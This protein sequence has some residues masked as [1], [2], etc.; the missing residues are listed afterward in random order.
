MSKYL[1]IDC[2]PGVDDAATILLAHQSQK[3]QPI[4]IST[5]AGNATHRHT[6][7]NARRLVHLIPANTP[8]YP[9]A[10]KPLIRELTTAPYIHGVDGL[11]GIQLPASEKAVESKKAWDALY[12]ALCRYGDDL[13]ILA[14]G[15]LTNIAIA[16]AKY[17]DFAQR[18]KR[19]IIMGGAAKGG[20]YTPAA[21][22]NIYV[23][24]EAAEKVFMSGIPIFMFG[25]DVT[26][27]SYLTEEDLDALENQSSPQAKFMVDCLQLSKEFAKTKN[28][29]GVPLHDVCTLLYL[30]KPKLFSFKKAWVRVETG[31]EITRGKTVTDL[32]S[33][34]QM[35]PKNTQV[36]LVVRREDFAQLF[37]EMMN[38]YSKG[39]LCK[40]IYI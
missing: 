7:D 21:E 24:P 26:L 39:S 2:D 19:L 29:K 6:F 16:L 3:F 17:P 8:V 34:K 28:L 25:L 35:E 23:D 9:G 40:H 13:E 22:F 27:Q 18:L 36:A 5:V 20:N 14:I 11:G 32:Y 30:E 15:P 33:D 31:G 38:R 4:G 1:W 10:D 37:L 12:E